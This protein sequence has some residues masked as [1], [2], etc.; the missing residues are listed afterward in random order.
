MD[1]IVLYTEEI[2]D[3]GEAAEELF[4]QA[5]SFPLKK[6]TLAVLFAEEE[7]DYPALY[8][9]LAARWDFPVVG[10]TTLA[11]LLGEHGCCRTGISVLLLSADDCAFAVGMTDELDRNNYREEIASLCMS[12]REELPGAPKII[13]TYGGMVAS[14]KNVPED[15][16]IDAIE[17]VFW[18]GLPIFG[19]VASDGFSFSNFRVFCKDRVTQSGQAIVLIAGSVD[20]I[21]VSTNS[22]ENRAD[23][24]YEVT[25]VRNNQVLRLG[26]GTFVDTLRRENMEVSKPNVVGDYF[27]SPF[28]LSIDLGDGDVA[29]ITRT[30]SLLNLET[31]AGVFLGGVPEG[32]IL[33]IG[34]MSQR[35]VQKSVEQAFSKILAMLPRDGK[36]RTLICNSCA[37]R[38]LAMASN[39]SAEA[40]TYQGRLPENVS[41]FGMYGNGELCPIQGNRT[42]KL[43]NFFH[44]FTF[45]IMAI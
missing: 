18:K 35:D 13:L 2:D 8:E 32:S 36:H 24:S 38:F 40:E 27:L 29:E 45:T 25:E 20:P 44:N 11:M 12:L 41:L 1:S 3:L 34:I 14:E 16:V 4:A 22:L 7:T 26:N 42:G 31:G 23:F 10:C 6:H 17:S 19:G 15:E 37:A 33:S 9:L 39:T 43:H 28:A 21:F 5:E 30:L